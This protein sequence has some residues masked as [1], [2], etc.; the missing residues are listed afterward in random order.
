MLS[1]QFPTVAAVVQAAAVAVVEP[2]NLDTFVD[3]KPPTQ[4]NNLVGQSV[5]QLLEE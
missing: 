5:H 4:R 2:D 1:A 3:N